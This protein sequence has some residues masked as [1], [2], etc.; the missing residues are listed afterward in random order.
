MSHNAHIFISY[1][2]EDSEFALRLARDLRSKGVNI[3]LDQLDIPPGVR[4]DRAIEQ[5]LRTCDRLLIILSP[6]SVASENVLD[7][8]DF[9]FNRK[10]RIVPILYRPC[11]IPLRLGR[12]QHIDFTSNYDQKLTVL[13]GELKEAKRAETAEAIVPSPAK[14]VSPLKHF[15]RPAAAI[16]S[17]VLLVVLLGV[18]ALTKFQRWFLTPVST[19]VH[20]YYYIWPPTH[21]SHL[22]GDRM[23]E[24]VSATALVPSRWDWRDQGK[25]PIVKDQGRCGSQYAFAAIAN[26]ESKILVDDAGTYDFSENNAKECNWQ[27]RNNYQYPPGIP[28]GGCDGGNYFMLANLFSQKSTV[29]ESCDPYVPRDISCNDTCPHIKTLLDWRIISSDAVPDTA[30][31]KGYIHTYGPVYTSMYAGDGDAWATEFSNYDGSY[32]LYYPGT[33]EPNHAALIVGWEDDLYHAGGTGGWIVKNSWGTDWGD[34]GYFYIAYGSA[35]IGMHSSFMYAWQDYDPHGDII[36][37]DEGGWTSAV[38]LG[39]T[40]G[41]G[42]C[43]F[44]PASNTYVTRVEF[45]TTDVTTDIDIYIYDDFD[46]TSLS[47]L[48]WSDLDNSFNEAGYH[49]MVVNPP[50]VVTNGDDVIAVV[51]FTNYS[52]EF[53]VPVDHIGPYEVKRTYTSPNGSRWTDEGQF[54][55]DVAIRLRTSDMAAHTR[56]YANAH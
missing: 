38:G 9:A 16:W 52:L 30:V 50:L 47:N 41:W 13:L 54:G 42:L 51:K 4:W 29:L 45:W 27:E 32:A 17:A 10:K 24:G 43:K 55:H 18:F 22:K 31:L 21:L 2:R 35:S 44:V 40:T 15:P 28:W 48:L 33:E 37:Y 25:V 23:P 3:W 46:G 34:V 53:P 39:S 7:E 56:A 26:I 12:L 14:P 19:H 49:G 8:V 20:N 6:A 1:A 5:A 36:Y 11:E